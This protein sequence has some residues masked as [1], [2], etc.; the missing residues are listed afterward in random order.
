MYKIEVTSHYEELWRYNI[1]ISCGGY[2]AHAEQLYVTGCERITCEEFTVDPTRR[3][4]PPA[5]FD[6]TVPL[7]LECDEADNIHTTIYVIA[8]TLPED[9]MVENSPPFPITI[10]VFRDKEQLYAQ[11]HE[12]NQ[13]G[14]ASVNIKT[15]G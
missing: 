10:K 13:W 1:V 15:I 14:G 2:N 5:N 8:H 3:L 6:P 7:I 4:S 12:V 9:R 11:D